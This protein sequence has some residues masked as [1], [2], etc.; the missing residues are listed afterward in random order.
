LSEALSFGVRVLF[1]GVGAD[2]VA[3][4]YQMSCSSAGTG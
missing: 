3:G 2:A 4:H 1:G